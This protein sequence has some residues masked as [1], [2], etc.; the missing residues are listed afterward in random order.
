MPNVIHLKPC[1]VK[2]VY[3]MDAEFIDGLHIQTGPGT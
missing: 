1:L 2:P 3:R